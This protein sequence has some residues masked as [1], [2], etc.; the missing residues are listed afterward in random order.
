MTSGRPKPS[1]GIASPPAT[2]G[3]RRLEVTDAVR[4]VLRDDATQ[5]LVAERDGRILG[6]ACT[7]PARDDEGVALPA[8]TH[9]QMLFVRAENWGHGIGGALLDAVIEDAQR[10]RMQG[11][12]L[13]V[14]ENNEPATRLYAD[15]GFSHSG[16]VVEENGARIALWTRSLRSAEEPH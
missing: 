7:T 9:I 3:H 2:A 12:Q 10:R 8:V 5:L 14:L 1:G 6:I 16:R 13:W 4:T 11:A 15:R